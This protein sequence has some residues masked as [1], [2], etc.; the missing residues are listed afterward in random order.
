MWRK[1]EYNQEMS[2]QEE[3]E[4][5]QKTQTYVNELNRATKEWLNYNNKV[6]D[7]QISFL[8]NIKNKR[9]NIANSNTKKIKETFIK[10][11]NEFLSS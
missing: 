6:V 9:G 7:A 5:K 4:K 11:L 3:R 2:T 10:N 1:K 8:K